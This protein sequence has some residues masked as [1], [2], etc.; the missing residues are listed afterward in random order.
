MLWS[1]I[2]VLLIGIMSHTVYSHAQ[3]Y[4]AKPVRIIT[5]AAGGG[6]DFATRLISTPLSAAL[7]QQVIVDN[8]G[9]LAADIAA[10]AAPDGYTLLLNGS[11]LW[12]LPFMRENVGSNVSD[13]TGI[14][15]A[16]QTANILVI[17]PALPPRSVKDLIALA[18]ARPGELNFATSGTGN[19]VH[20]AGELFRSM[21]G[22]SI[23]RVN[24]KAASQALTD[25]V[26]G[27]TQLMF[28]VPGSALPHVA[29]GRLRALAVTSAQATPLAPG[30]PPVSATLP[31]YESVSYLAIFA[32]AGTPEAIVKRLNQEIVRVLMRAD[33]KEKFSTAGIDTVGNSPDELSALVKAE[34][35]RMGKVIKAAGIRAD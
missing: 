10:K 27:Q 1:P 13:F 18:R 12:L 21:S 34:V 28:A 9:V 24:Y 4:P 2:A 25:L 14:T 26:A 11:T 30:L 5:A 16:T 29:S 22:V 8:R 32:P 15:M 19:S 3:T 20:V 6:S 23:V 33:I 7:G 17:H 35:N 31:G